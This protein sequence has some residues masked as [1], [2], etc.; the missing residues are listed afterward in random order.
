[1]DQMCMLDPVGTIHRHWGLRSL[2]AISIYYIVLLNISSYI[3][4]M[5]VMPFVP[6]RRVDDM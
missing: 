2:G 3:S 1:M 6:K 4:S 5:S